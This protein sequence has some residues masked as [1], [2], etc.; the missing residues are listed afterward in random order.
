[1]RSVDGQPQG[2]SLQP[3]DRPESRTR[4]TDFPCFICVH[5][6]LNGYER[7]LAMFKA[8]VW[9]VV[10]TLIFFSGC[11]QMGE[12]PE[13]KEAE[14][15]GYYAIVSG[16]EYGPVDIDTLKKWTREGLIAPTTIIKKGNKCAWARDMRELKKDFNLRAKTIV[17]DEEGAEGELPETKIITSYQPDDD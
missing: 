13:K 12:I 2:L 10:F 8:P 16:K 9:L 7:R 6:W 15:P 4:L 17:D 1:V 11:G 3:K 14:V 5:L